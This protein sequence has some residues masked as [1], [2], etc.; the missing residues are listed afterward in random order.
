MINLTINI[1]YLFIMILI[2]I[3]YLIYRK[4]NYFNN[5]WNRYNNLVSIL[6]KSQDVAYQKIFRDDILVHSAS[7]FRINKEDI[8]KI[9]TKYIKLVFQCCGS[10]I[11]DDLVTIYGDIDSLT[12][13]LLNEFIF[14]VEQDEVTILHNVIDKENNL[15]EQEDK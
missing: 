14:K 5:I 3:I 12:V 7:G 1:N 9:R 8:N 15:D 13:I 11:L 4:D 6:E 2:P 10:K